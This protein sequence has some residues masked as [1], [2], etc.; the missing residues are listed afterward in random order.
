MTER[1]FPVA[2]LDAFDAPVVRPFLMF[3]GEFSTT[4]RLWTGYGVLYALGEE[5]TGSGV[6]L[7]VS[8]IQEGSDLVARGL[9]FELS[10]VPSEMIA[11]ALAEDYQGNAARVYIGAFDEAGELISDPGLLFGAT[12][13]TMTIEEDGESSTIQLAVENEL[14]SLE[15]DNRVLWTPEEQKLIYP[16]DTGF[17]SVARLQDTEVVWKA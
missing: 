3:E 9:T 7:K 13:D 16:D 14:I 5:W 15:R 10:G 4:L 6:I 11:L 8:P 12:M 2:L 17:D 1:N